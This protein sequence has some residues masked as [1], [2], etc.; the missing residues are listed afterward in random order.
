MSAQIIAALRSRAARLEDEA[1]QAL[2]TPGTGELPVLRSKVRSPEHLLL[3]A[4][5]FTAIADL[6]E[7]S[8]P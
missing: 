4:A 3:L 6:A 5:E 8:C 1:H 2:T 7:G